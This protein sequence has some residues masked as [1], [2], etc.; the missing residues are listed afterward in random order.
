MCLGC[1]DV[2]TYD[3]GQITNVQDGM[4]RT[5]EGV[6]RYGTVLSGPKLKATV[7]FSHWGLE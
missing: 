5:A 2:Y 4:Y 7:A 3:L 1:K 6:V